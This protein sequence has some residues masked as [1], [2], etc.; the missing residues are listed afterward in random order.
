MPWMVASFWIWVTKG[1]AASKNKYRLRESLS[2]A[3][4]H[5]YR[6]GE[7]ASHQY[8]RAVLLKLFWFCSPLASISRFHSPLSSRFLSPLWFKPFV[9]HWALWFCAIASL[10]FDHLTVH[11]YSS[12]LVG[13]PLQIFYSP[14]GEPFT[15]LRNTDLRHSL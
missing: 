14:W 15:R 3:F 5:F 7:V 1:F 10:L 13:S 2:Y 6:F 8:S 12:L 4:F 9:T 11:P